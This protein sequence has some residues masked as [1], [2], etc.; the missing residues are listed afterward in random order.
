MTNHVATV[1]DLSIF[2][3]TD[4]NKCKVISLTQSG[5][6]KP[7][8]TQIDDVGEKNAAKLVSMVY[9]FMDNRSGRFICNRRLFYVPEVP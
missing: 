1:I 2:Y 7:C 3:Q 9:F 5:L 6:A 4:Y 8:H